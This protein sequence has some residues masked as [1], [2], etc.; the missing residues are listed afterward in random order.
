MSNCSR[1]IV[2]L[3]NALCLM[4]ATIVL[5][6]QPARAEDE[7]LPSPKRRYSSRDT[8]RTDMQDKEHADAS[9][10]IFGRAIVRTTDEEEQRAG[11]GKEK[12]A[13]WTTEQIVGGGVAGAFVVV[14]GWFATRPKKPDPEV[15]RLAEAMRLRAE[16]DKA[17][18]ESAERLQKEKIAA[19]LLAR[20]LEIESKE[21]EDTAR[22]EH[23]ERLAKL[24]VDKLKLQNEK[25]DGLNRGRALKIRAEHPGAVAVDD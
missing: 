1:R 2:A 10:A 15:V 17:S 3:V 5:V 19:D 7:E 25:R 23:S 20:R 18:V 4:L 24:G 22:R 13:G 9:N 14:A 11:K 12:E 21:R 8:M 16:A 6:P